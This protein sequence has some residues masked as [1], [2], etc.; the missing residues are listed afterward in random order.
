MKDVFLHLRIKMEIQVFCTVTSRIKTRN[1]K[2]RKDHKEYINSES[3][4]ISNVPE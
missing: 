1:V 4:G 2:D 3:Q